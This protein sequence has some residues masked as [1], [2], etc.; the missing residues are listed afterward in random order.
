MYQEQGHLQTVFSEQGAVVAVAFVVEPFA[1]LPLANAASVAPAAAP[2][3]VGPDVRELLVVVCVG[4][5]VTE[6]GDAIAVGRLININQT[7]II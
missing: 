7:Y 1:W 3:A 5:A 2:A 4:E 6:P